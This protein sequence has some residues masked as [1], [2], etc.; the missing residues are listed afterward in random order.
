MLEDLPDPTDC[1][2]TEAFNRAR[3]DEAFDRYLDSLDEPD[4]SPLYWEVR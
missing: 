3:S 1:P 4:P 2:G